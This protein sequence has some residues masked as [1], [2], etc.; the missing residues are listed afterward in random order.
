MKLKNKIICIDF[1]GTIYEDGE[2]L[3]GAFEV[4]T[5]IKEAG[6]IIVLWTCREDE[7]KTKYLTEAVQFCKKHGVEFD[8]VNELP[9]ELDFR[10]DYVNRRKPYCSLFIDDRN[11][12][13]F[14]GWEKVNELLFN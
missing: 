4:I 6:A 9:I 2:A 8:Y 13:G 14:I 11:I 12:G 5:K 3:P 10:P 7:K 1:D